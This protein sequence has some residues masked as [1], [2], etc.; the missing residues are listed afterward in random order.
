[1]ANRVNLSPMSPIST[2]RR[3][4]VIFLGVCLLL[5]FLSLVIL[6]AFNLNFL[7]PASPLQTLVFLTLS[8]LAFLLFVVVLVL[9]VRNV[10]KLYADQ[11]SRVLGTRLR[12]RML[13]GAV[14]V[15]IVP[16]V[17]MSAFSYL[18]MNRSVE[19]WF[20][21]PGTQMRDDANRRVLDITRYIDSNARAEADSIALGIATTT[22][23]AGSR[24]RLADLYSNELHRHNVTLQGGF[25][26]IY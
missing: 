3:S 20:S 21:Q 15:S 4:L 11:R 7:N 18:L 8:I 23:A 26:I 12:T 6:N 9:L 13:W 22:P 17:F 2:R 19:R 14:L 25:A 16:L 5:L 10:L 1:M 24:M